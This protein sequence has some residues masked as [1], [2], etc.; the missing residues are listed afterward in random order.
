RIDLAL[1]SAQRAY[2]VIP[3]SNAQ[4]FQQ[5]G[6]GVQTLN[7]ATAWLASV[8]CLLAGPFGDGDP[9]RVHPNEAY[10]VFGYLGEAIEELSLA[11]Q[12]EMVAVAWSGDLDAYAAYRESHEAIELANALRIQAGECYFTCG[13]HPESLCCQ[14]GG[15]AY[16]F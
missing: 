10:S 5:A 11:A 8:R 4:A 15:N 3:P 9:S 6:F 12:Y 16:C 1:A 13:L 7:E 14:P 2:A